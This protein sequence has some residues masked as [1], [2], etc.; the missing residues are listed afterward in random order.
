[1]RPSPSRAAAGREDRVPGGISVG[2]SSRSRVEVMGLPRSG[3]TSTTMPP[4]VLTTDFTDTTDRD[5]CKA[6]QTASVFTPRVTMCRVVRFL[7]WPLSVPIRAIRGQNEL[8]RSGSFATPGGEREPSRQLRQIRGLCVEVAS[9]LL[10]HGEVVLPS[11]K[12]M[13]NQSPEP[14]PALAGARVG[15][16]RL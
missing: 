8:R 12:C 13:L 16:A 7:G 2:A 15:A 14:T 3:R 1:M 6:S 5:I 4:L 9:R 11:P 10:G